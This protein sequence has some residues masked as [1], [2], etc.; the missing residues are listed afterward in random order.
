MI[1][2]WY[3]KSRNAGTSCISLWLILVRVLLFII[4]LIVELLLAILNNT[5]FLYRE[6][7][8]TY[9]ST[10]FLFISQLNS[11]LRAGRKLVS[12]LYFMIVYDQN[13]YFFLGLIPTP[14]MA[15]IFS[16]YWNQYRNHIWIENL[17]SDGIGY[18]LQHMCVSCPL[19]LVGVLVYFHFNLVSLVLAPFQI[20]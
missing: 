9:Q 16:R 13:Y 15:N 19:V 3:Q 18:L 6:Q 10:S 1:P 11:S 12:E 7:R 17:V 5:Q 2:F 20:G 14:K 8:L 4:Q